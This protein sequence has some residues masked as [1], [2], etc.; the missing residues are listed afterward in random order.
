[1]EAAANTWSGGVEDPTIRWC[2]NQTEFAPNLATGTRTA[3]TTS[4]AIGAGYSNTRIMLSGCAWGAANAA[5]AYNGGGKSDWHLPSRDELNELYSKKTTVGGLA[6]DL[7]PYWS[8]S[9][10]GEDNSFRQFFFAGQQA[11]GFKNELYRVRPV[12]AFG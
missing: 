12:R 5:A 6:E 1:M 4:N 8:S 2:S 10:N 9:E 11:G 3:Q 7:N